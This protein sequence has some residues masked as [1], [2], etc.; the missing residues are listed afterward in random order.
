METTI[1]HNR[2]SAH[3]RGLIFSAWGILLLVS[4]LPDILL[5]SLGIPEPGW[6]LWSKIVFL[7]GCLGLSL[8][9]KTLRSLTPFL[10]VFL[11]YQLLLFVTADWIWHSDGF[12]SWLDQQ[13]SWTTRQ[14]IYQV[15][16]LGITALM[17]L[18]L[19]VIQRDRQIFSWQ[20]E[21][22]MLPSSRFAGWGSKKEK[23]GRGRSLGL[24][25]AFCV[26]YPHFY[27]TGADHNL[28]SYR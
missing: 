4:E 12:Q 1:V 20:W 23:A 25:H 6:L 5:Q 21:K 26:R 15:K 22:S 10:L 14:F 18:L 2:K 24:V 17:L 3:Q 28:R 7:T 8:L 11:A 19:W 27:P 9:G 16:E 13:A